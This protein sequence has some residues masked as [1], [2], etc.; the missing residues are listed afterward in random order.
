MEKA[1]GQEI[2]GRILVVDD[3]KEIQNLLHKLLTKEGYEVNVAT[4]PEEALKKIESENYDV[5][6]LDLMLP[7]VKGTDIIQEIKRRQPN[8]AVIIM[9]AFGTIPNT[10]EAI[11]K[12]AFDYIEKPFKKG[13]I[14]H[15]VRNAIEQQRL[16]K[17]FGRRANEV[18]KSVSN[19]LRRDILEIL[20]E[21]DSMKLME[22]VKALGVRDHTKVSFHLRKLK[23]QE[24]VMQN[25]SRSYRITPKGIKVLETVWNL[26]KEFL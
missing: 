21:K 15:A 10:V 3:E 7:G 13:E 19:P 18:L 4:L 1:G 6:L 2:T 14:Q 12:G 20:F 11:K 8:C 22:M 23:E 16:K 24:L 5:V 26:E 17:R 25:G 9:T